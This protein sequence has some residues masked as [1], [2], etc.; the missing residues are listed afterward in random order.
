MNFPNSFTENEK[1][2]CLVFSIVFTGTYE[3]TMHAQY[4]V[5]LGIGGINLKRQK[6]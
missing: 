3:Q 5:K 2:T 1:S 4:P 6:N